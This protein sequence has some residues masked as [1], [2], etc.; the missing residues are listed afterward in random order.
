MEKGE[1]LNRAA[2]IGHPYTKINKIRQ[3]P[4]MCHKNELK[5]DHG[6]TIGSQVWAVHSDFLLK[7]GAWKAGKG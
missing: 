4:Y 3:R 2:A 5:V 6:V 1:S 7:S